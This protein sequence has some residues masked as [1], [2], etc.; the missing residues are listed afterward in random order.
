MKAKSHQSDTSSQLASEAEE[1]VKVKPEVLAWIQ[2]HGRPGGAVASSALSTASS[3]YPGSLYNFSHRGA[4]SLSTASIMND[5]GS[6]RQGGYSGNEAVVYMREHSFS[7]TL[8]VPVRWPSR[9]TMQ[10]AVSVVIPGAVLEQMALQYSHVLFADQLSQR[11]IFCP[12]MSA[13]CRW[14]P[15]RVSL[16]RS[17]SSNV[18]GAWGLRWENPVMYRHC[19]KKWGVCAADY[20]KDRKEDWEDPEM[21]Q[22]L[23]LWASTRH[24]LFEDFQPE[25]PL[26][27]SDMSAYMDTNVFRLTYIDADTE[28]AKSVQPGKVHTNYDQQEETFYRVKEESQVGMILRDYIPEFSEVMRQ[29]PPELDG[30]YPEVPKSLCE[31]ALV[32]MHL[33]VRSYVG[34]RGF[35]EDQVF[36]F[37]PLP[38]DP[39]GLV[40]QSEGFDTLGSAV[41]QS[42]N[43]RPSS[44]DAMGRYTFQDSEQERTNYVIPCRDY[45]QAARYGDMPA[46]IIVT[47]KLDI[48]PAMPLSDEEGALLGNISVANINK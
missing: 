28:Y 15:Y 10:D 37:V 26:V 22:Q 1:D 33:M 27:L 4:H 39:P 7:V 6:R 2:K 29:H 44:K 18:T 36:L 3:S 17:Y 31:R 9:N 19:N 24:G 47:L 8:D 48:C 12:P 23:L 20:D 5:M 35:K 14:F 42:M 46:E 34:Y 45:D 40:S 41:R 11:K 32:R 25:T 16:V 38:A 30:W 13:M 43:T 21:R